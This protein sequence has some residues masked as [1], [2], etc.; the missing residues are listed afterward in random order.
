LTAFLTVSEARRDAL[1]QA[2]LPVP[3]AVRVSALVDTGAS[4][5]CV[6]PSFMAK[7]GL[8]PTGSVP[9][10]T[11]STGGTPHVAHQYDAGLIVPGALQDH[12]PLIFPTIAIVS[13]EL[14]V[15]GIDAL[16]GRDI[17][18]NCV[19]NYNGTAGYFTLAY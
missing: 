16:I 8:T 7:L 5:T 1:L 18:S 12:T 14:L 2:S 3:D 15:Q 6:D 9:V 13:A 4:C 11:P 17:L 10:N 19:L